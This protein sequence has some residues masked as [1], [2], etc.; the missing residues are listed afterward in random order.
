VTDSRA[1]CPK[2][3]GTEPNRWQRIANIGEVMALLGFLAS[4]LTKYNTSDSNPIFTYF[5]ISLL[6]FGLVLFFIT[7]IKPNEENTN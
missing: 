1:G 5:G 6:L 2:H 7:L 4:I 3:Q